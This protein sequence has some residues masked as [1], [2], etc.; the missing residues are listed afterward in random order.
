M[1]LGGGLLQ[2]HQLLA[3]AVGGPSGGMLPS[4]KAGLPFESN[5]LR[6]AGTMMG[7]GAVRVLS[8]RESV[9][10]EAQVAAEFFRNQSCGRCTPCRV[11]TAELA[12]I[13]NKMSEGLANED[14]LAQLREVASVLQQTSTCG[15]GAAAAGRV[16]SVLRYWPDEVDVRSAGAEPQGIL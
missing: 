2:D 5:S 14:D 1:D 4:G 8:C 16:S 11:G 6:Q 12:R 10:K 7:T 15:L 3:I 13:W 9:I